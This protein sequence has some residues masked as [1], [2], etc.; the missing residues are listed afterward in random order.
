MLNYVQVQVNSKLQS[1]IQKLSTQQHCMLR[2][3]SSTNLPYMLTPALTPVLHVPAPQTLQP[4]VL[5]S[6]DYRAAFRAPL[7]SLQPL[8]YQLLSP[9]TLPQP[10][11]LAQHIVQQPTI[12]SCQRFLN[13]K[14]EQIQSI[15]MLMTSGVLGIPKMVAFT[16]EFAF[17]PATARTDGL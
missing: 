17:E 4:R 5:I 7:E 2:A 14:N 8:L 3:Q 15:T 9:Y 1:Q 6:Q 12:F 11:H 16:F 10:P 13:A